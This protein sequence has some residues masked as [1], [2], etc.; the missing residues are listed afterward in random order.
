MFRPFYIHDSRGSGK[1]TSSSPR[2]FTAVVEPVERAAT[3]ALGLPG[4]PS[5][6][7]AIRVAFC[8]NKDQFKKKE[9]RSFAHAE[10]AKIINKRALPEFVAS[11]YCVVHPQEVESFQYWSDHYNYLLKYVI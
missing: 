7:C 6:Y 9:G 3:E 8:S 11:L 10:P 2:G 4:D 1:L 5:K